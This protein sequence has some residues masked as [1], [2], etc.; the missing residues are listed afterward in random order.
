MP[1]EEK[2]LILVVDDNPQNIQVLGNLLENRGYELAFFLSGFQALEF[3]KKDKPELILL[4]VMMPEMDGYE[5]CKIIKRDES[6]ND[7]PIIFLTAKTEVDDIVKGFEVGAVD[8]VTKPF[9][10]PELLARIKTHVEL[11]RARS[12][13]DTLRGIIPVCAKCRKVR[14]TEGVWD[15]FDE[16]IEKNF[17]AMVSHSLCEECAKELYGSQKWFKKIID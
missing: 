9:Q 17:D 5:V 10:S 6:I 11:G 4:D 2:A 15:Q 8:Y 13:I 1:E 14:D 3:L 12:E 7:I 16:Y